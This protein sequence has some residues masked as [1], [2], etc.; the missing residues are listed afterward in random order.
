LKQQKKETTL[1]KHTPTDKKARTR[2]AI[3]DAAQEAFLLNGYHKTDMNHIA[4]IVGIDKR[5]IYRY[6]KSKEALAFVIWQNVLT[7]VEEYADGAEGSTGYERLKNILHRYTDNME[8]NTNIL[9]F[10]GEFD[11]VFSGEYPHIKEAEQFVEH[12][13]KSENRILKAIEDGVKDGSIR[14]DIDVSL[15]AFTVANLMIAMGERVVIR[16]IHLKAEHGHT[17]PMITQSAWMVLES[18]KKENEEG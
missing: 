8:Q 3:V 18:L 12:I 2:S 14:S 15:T 9:R 13:I 11:H 1:E 7:Y 10:L 16:E 5:T 17:F 6:F 4:E